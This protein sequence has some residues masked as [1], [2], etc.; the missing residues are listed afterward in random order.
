MKL[1]GFD[2]PPRPTS[3]ERPKYDEWLDFIRRKMVETLYV[4]SSFSHL[5]HRKY[6]RKRV[7]VEDD[8]DEGIDYPTP[9]GIKDYAAD[10]SSNFQPLYEDDDDEDEEEEDDDAEGKGEKKMRE[11]KPSQFNY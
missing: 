10:E 9:S 5:S 2:E 1:I 3:P 11:L 7:P 4:S 6:H 8:D